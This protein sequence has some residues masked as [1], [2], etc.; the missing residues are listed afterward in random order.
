M[1]ETKNVSNLQKK[2]IIEYLKSGKRFDERA[3]NEYRD[4]K[5]ELG[6]SQNA[7]SSCS[8]KF[9]KTEVYAGVKMAL[10]EPY[11][12]NP[13]EGTFMVSLELGPMADS[14]FDSGAP[15]IDA[16]EM[17]RVID[18]GLRESGFIDFKKMCVEEGKKV[19]QV[20]LDIYAINND[21]NLFD[22]VGL[23]GLVA[24]ANAK[25]P[26]INEETGK[27]EHEFTDVSLPLNKEKMS[28]NITIHKIGDKL[29]LDPSKEEEE[30]SDY[31]LSVAVADNKGEAR[32]TAMQ[33][34]KESGI[35]A[36]DMQNI[37]K[38]V[39]EQFSEM[40]PKISKIVWGK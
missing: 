15:K 3:T 39:E 28:Y 40:F 36:D 32:I 24:L 27:I 12:D 35:T 31:R 1:S 38:L 22:A 16:I 25:L 23:A 29:V 9:G 7:E 11:S 30:I 2:R 4:I 26:K 19:W 34:G 5:V 8:V 13:D 37:L 20:F 33:K 17:G 6:I 21:G 10:V 14:N 18:R